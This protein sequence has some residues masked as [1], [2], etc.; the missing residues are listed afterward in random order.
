MNRSGTALLLLTAA[1][2]LTPSEVL[3]IVDDIDLP[4][5]RLRLRPSGGPGSH[6]G[7]RDIVDA[8]GTAFPRLRLGI[9]GTEPWDDLAE[10]VTSDLEPDE[11]SLLDRALDRACDAVDHVLTHGISSAMNEFNRVVED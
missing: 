9:R 1:H 7:L 4:L 10:Y 8:I 2:A 3:V 11:L 5:G 6:N